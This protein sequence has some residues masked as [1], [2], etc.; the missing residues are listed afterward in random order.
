MSYLMKELTTA[1]VENFA[2]VEW[3]SRREYRMCA[4]DQ[5]LAFGVAYVP[6]VDSLKIQTA[7]SKRPKK[8]DLA[9]RQ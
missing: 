4:S 6:S 1:S 5:R 8:H 9:R 2:T 3:M 7:K